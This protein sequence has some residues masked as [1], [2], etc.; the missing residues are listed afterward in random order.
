MKWNARFLLNRLVTSCGFSVAAV[1]VVNA[2]LAL[3]VA[4]TSLDAFIDVLLGA[5][6]FAAWLAL[7]AGFLVSSRVCIVALILFALR[8]LYTVSV[9]LAPG[10]FLYFELYV[11]SVFFLVVAPLVLSALLSFKSINLHSAG[12]KSGN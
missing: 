1:G 9:T 10:D 6:V 7:F 4:T 3:R 5:L 12:R 11:V 2:S 8:N